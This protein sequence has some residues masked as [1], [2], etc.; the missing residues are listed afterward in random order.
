MATKRPVAI[1]SEMNPTFAPTKLPPNLKGF[2][3]LG[4]MGGNPG[5]RNKHVGASTVKPEQ[6]FDDSSTIMGREA[7]HSTTSGHLHPKAS[8]NKTKGNSGRS[9]GR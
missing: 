1:S 8:N 6:G 3:I 5:N 4:G 9:L 2:R 7:T